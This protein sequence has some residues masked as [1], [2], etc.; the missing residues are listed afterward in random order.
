MIQPPTENSSDHQQPPKGA[1]AAAQAA[2]EAEIARIEAELGRGRC[3]QS[4][5]TKNVQTMKMKNQGVTVSSLRLAPSRAIPKET[6]GVGAWHDYSN[7][8]DDIDFDE[9]TF[10]E[11][12]ILQEEQAFANA[13][14]VQKQRTEEILL[15]QQTER[16]E[17]EHKMADQKKQKEEEQRKALEDEIKAMEAAISVAAQKK[18][19]PK[20][21]PSAK[22]SQQGL[23][24]KRLEEEIRKLD[25]DIQKQSAHKSTQSSDIKVTAAPVTPSS[26]AIT[27]RSSFL[28]SIKEYPTHGCKSDDTVATEAFVGAK[29]MHTPN[30]FLA[31]ISE[32]ASA[33][34]VRLEDGEPVKQEFKPNA[35][36]AMTEPARPNFL[37]ALVCAATAR[38]QR[39]EETGG[40]LF[41]QEIEPEVEATDTMAPHLSFNLAEMVS[42]KAL[43]REKRL[44]DGGEKRMTEVKEKKE[45]KQVFNNICVDAAAMGRL[46]RMKEKVV[47]AVAVEKT[48]QEEWKSNGLL[49]IQWRSN[50]MSIIH[51]AAQLGAQTKRKEKVVSNSPEEEQDWDFE[52]GDKPFS[53]RMQQLLTLNAKVGEGQH[54]VD[55]LVLGRKEENLDSSSML[56]R[57]MAHYSRI[58]DVKLPKPNAPSLLAIQKRRQRKELQQEAD[59]FHRPLLDISNAVAEIAWERR[60]RLDRPGSMPKMKEQCPCPYCGTASPFQTFAYRE[61]EN[62]HKHMIKQQKEIE[63]AEKLLLKEERERKALE[64]QERLQRQREENERQAAERMEQEPQVEEVIEKEPKLAEEVKDKHETN[65][66]T[67]RMVRKVRKTRPKRPPPEDIPHLSPPEDAA[68]SLEVQPPPEQSPPH[69]S[70]VS[71]DQGC[72]CAIL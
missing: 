45:Y 52:E 60:T 64:L 29:A 71:A 2:L 32:A 18:R 49:A 47:E 43:D 22:S 17:R 27:N 24:Q 50:H 62:R 69:P 19:A 5:S 57:P 66:P 21:R 68:W 6:E 16:L 10:A 58:E 72:A 41:M 4:S 11:E 12:M 33:R 38:N 20:R 61:K 28:D 54:K 30:P 48:Q 37:G 35:P 70:V 9:T 40:Q 53:P 67:P 34:E 55:K 14:T 8:E 7:R 23:Q 25:E 42:K 59:P 39:L 63:D 65:P 1:A 3:E 36:D 51:E 31:A 26:P 46:T 13:S 15:Q 56:V 44:E